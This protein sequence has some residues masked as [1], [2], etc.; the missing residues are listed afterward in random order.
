MTHE[1]GVYYAV[2]A[3]DAKDWY[4]IGEATIRV[5]ADF[6]GYDQADLKLGEVIFY[7]GSFLVGEVT[8]YDFTPYNTTIRVEAGQVMELHRVY[9]P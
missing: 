5:S 7:P 2:S 9:M 3:N 1:G 4:E 6:I 8:N